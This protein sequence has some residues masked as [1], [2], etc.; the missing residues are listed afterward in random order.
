MNEE[1]GVEIPQPNSTSTVSKTDTSEDSVGKWKS[2]LEAIREDAS[3]IANSDDTIDGKAASVL[4]FEITLI[5]GYL[6][7]ALSNLSW[8]ALILAYLGLAILIGSCIV[9]L[10]LI[11]PKD[12]KT[13]TVDFEANK[14]YYKMSELTLIKQLLSDADESRRIN[15]EVLKRKSTQ[16]KSAL[17]LLIVAVILLIIPQLLRTNLWNLTLERRERGVQMTHRVVRPRLQLRR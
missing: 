7:I 8:Q 15:L 12:Y 9:L 5:I 2:I 10:K 13:P 3:F 1:S 17:K 16:Y 4:G 14:K 11:W 6:T